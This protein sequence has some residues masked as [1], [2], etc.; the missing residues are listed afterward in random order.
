MFRSQGKVCC[1]VRSPL[2]MQLEKISIVS[3]YIYREE[4]QK[5]HHL[6][7]NRVQINQ[8][9]AFPRYTYLLFPDRANYIILQV[10]QCKDFHAS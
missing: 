5:A 9:L 1:G 2:A 4:N 3:I 10:A 7:A 8:F 6:L